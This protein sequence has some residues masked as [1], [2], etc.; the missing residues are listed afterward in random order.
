MTD[1]VV[2]TLLS[3][4]PYLGRILTGRIATGVAKMNMPCKTIDLNGNVVET[5]RLTKLFTFKGLQKVPV[6]EAVAGDIIYALL[7]Q[8][9]EQ[10]FV[11]VL[12]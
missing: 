9:Q 2:A 4:D 7:L 11:M 8:L 10:F 6:D 12:A 3:A 5:G 1:C